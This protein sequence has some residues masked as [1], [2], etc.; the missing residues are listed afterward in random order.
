VWALGLL[1]FQLLTGEMYW[2]AATLA[3]P[4]RSQLVEEMRREPATP[5]DARAAELGLEARLPPGFAD[6][7]AHCVQR[8]VSAR[9]G[10]AA[11][12]IPPLLRLLAHE[13][14]PLEARR[15]VLLE[16][17][18]A[19]LD[20]S[21]GAGLPTAAALAAEAPPAPPITPPEYARTASP[22]PPS[23]HGTPDHAPPPA[24]DG[25]AGHDRRGLRDELLEGV[26]E[27]DGGLRRAGCEVRGIGR[28][29]ESGSGN[30][31]GEERAHGRQRTTQC[32]RRPALHPCRASWGPVSARE[33]ERPK[34]VS[35]ADRALPHDIDALPTTDVVCGRAF[36][37][38]TRASCPAL[39]DELLLV[40]FRLEERLTLAD[41]LNPMSCRH[42]PRLLAGA[43]PLV[44]GGAGSSCKAGEGGLVS[45]SY[46]R[47]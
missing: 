20:A 28:T 12:A 30:K 9:F 24:L 36:L 40:E 39:E 43:G 21:S 15:A 46:S 37:R 5:A 32:A 34:R 27:R 7:F 38:A 1:A 23:V 11:A 35:S 6:W 4:T 33:V 19:A 41:R 14:A 17:P 8:D 45:P 2:R 18:R 3:A 22:T 26:G 42:E 29:D 10:D 13:E 16:A 44:I 47:E 25:A 31:A